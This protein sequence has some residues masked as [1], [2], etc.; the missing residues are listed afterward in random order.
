MWQRRQSVL[1]GLTSLCWTICHQSRLILVAGMKLQ[2][3]TMLE[4]E[5][6]CT[7]KKSTC[8]KNTLYCT[9]VSSIDSFQSKRVSEQS[10]STDK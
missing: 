8:M 7:P 4:E 10:L 5:Q 3:L 2:T 6:I 1:E 9:Q